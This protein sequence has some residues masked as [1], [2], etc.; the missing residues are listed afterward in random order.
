M[1]NRTDSDILQ[2]RILKRRCDRSDKLRE[3]LQKR[4]D[5]R[6]DARADEEWVTMNG[7]P[8]KIGDD[9]TPKG[10]IGAKIMS[11]QEKAAELAPR[12][13]A[14]A[15]MGISEEFEYE[16]AELYGDI[17]PMSVGRAY[18]EDHITAEQAEYLEELALHDV[19]SRE[20]YGEDWIGT[21]KEWEWAA[22]DTMPLWALEDLAGQYGLE[23]SDSDTRKGLQD[24][25][26]NFQ[27]AEGIVPEWD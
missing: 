17:T 20:I 16:F 22:V 15:G 4:I 21:Q 6:R 14:M 25:I 11:D 27:E 19:V 3:A 12:K 24:R 9:G 13:E 8:I 10:E 5:A 7:T 23:T 26:K 2:E 1:A 18:K